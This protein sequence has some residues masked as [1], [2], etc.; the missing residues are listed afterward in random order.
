MKKMMYTWGLILGLTVFCGQSYAAPTSTILGQSFSDDY[1]GTTNGVD[2]SYVQSGGDVISDAGHVNSY[3]IA[4]MTVQIYTDESRN[5]WLKVSIETNYSENIG[6]YGTTYGD[7]F[8]SSTGYSGDSTF[9]DYA[10]D[11]SSGTLYSI[12]SSDAVLT[13]NYCASEDVNGKRDWDDGWYRPDQ[14]VLVDTSNSNAKAV[15]SSTGN[16]TSTDTEGYYEI[17][18]NITGLSLDEDNLGFY[19]TMTCGNDVI[20]C[21]TNQVP[22]PAGGYLLGLGMLAFAGIQRRRY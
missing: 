21:G 3:D 17:L 8:I 18:I 15:N 12:A 9:W 22:V 1:I 20:Q 16:S 4:G 6:N 14:M 13:S 11:V 10:F 7:L 19:W 2:A 5:S